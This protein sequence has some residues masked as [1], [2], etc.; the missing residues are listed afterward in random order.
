MARYE[1]PG[2]RDPDERDDPRS[3][4]ED[5]FDRRSAVPGDLLAAASAARAALLAAVAAETN[6][7]VP[8]GPSVAIEGQAG[9][10]PRVAGRVRDIAVSD[11]GQR[12]YLAA[13]NGGVWY[14]SDAGTNWL[15]LGSAGSTPSGEAAAPGPNSLVTTCLCVTFG[16]N[17]DGSGDTVYVGTGEIRPRSTGF[18]GDSS[19]VI[20]VLKLSRTIADIQAHPEINPWRREANNLSRMGIFRIAVDPGNPNTLIA[21]TSAGLF[22]RQGPFV[23]GAN[24]TRIT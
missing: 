12:V 22:K 15:P 16:A 1:W 24:W 18:P 21:A 7:W 5:I 14:S 19:E 17:P 6:V 9:S 13:A 10:T 3:R 4:W 23:E 11:D 20:G 2:D 8:I